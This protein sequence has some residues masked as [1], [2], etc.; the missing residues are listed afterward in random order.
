MGTQ[1]SSQGLGFCYQ[2]DTYPEPFCFSLFCQL[3]TRPV[4]LCISYLNRTELAR[5]RPIS[6]APG[7][8]AQDWPGLAQIRKDIGSGA[9]ER[10]I[11]KRERHRVGGRAVPIKNTLLLSEQD[12]SPRRPLVVYPKKLGDCPGTRPPYICIRRSLRSHSFAE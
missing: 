2:L 11:K 10:P 6:S 3:D 1:L 4:L 12:R 5:I 7:R 8:T 9:G